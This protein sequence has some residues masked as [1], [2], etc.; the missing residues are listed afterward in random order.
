MAN[1]KFKIGDTAYYRTLNN[2]VGRGVVKAI[3]GN[4]AILVYEIRT[5]FMT[6]QRT[7]AQPMAELFTTKS[8]C[9]AHI[10]TACGEMGNPTTK[11]CRQFYKIGVN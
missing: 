9:E 5:K 3:K 11:I 7:I 1:K 8:A 2:R 6:Q 10:T 4:D